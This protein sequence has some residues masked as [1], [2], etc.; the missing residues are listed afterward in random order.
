MFSHHTRVI[1][2][3][4]LFCLV[5][6]SSCTSPAS[7][8]TFSPTTTV[9]KAPVRLSPT[10]R[11]AGTPD[12]TPTRY[13]SHVVLRGVGRP[14]DLV[15]DEQG[16]LVFSDFYNGTISRLNANGSV[17][18]LVR[19]VA[20]PE[21]MVI[22]ADG[23]MII[24]EQ[25]TNRI[26]SLAPGTQM[27]KVLRALPGSP[28][29]VRC[30]DGVDGIALDAAT[31]TLIVPDS[32]I[33]NVYR[34]SLDGHTLTLLASGITRPVGAVVDARGTIYVADECGGALWKIASSG[35]KTR[36]GGFGMLDDVA[37][38]SR[39]NILVTDLAPTIHALVRV[40]LSTGRHETLASRGFIEPQG[41]LIDDHDNIFVADDYAN[42]IMEYKPT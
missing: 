32:P 4:T 33:G 28:R 20:G 42:I 36:M 16:H 39:G 34:M 15:F 5:V 23:T 29:P 12:T 21:G 14:D 6:L 25:R 35:K 9:T 11:T 7:S 22:L 24:A 40:R 19:G 30:K 1:C 37:I 31:N 8:A 3:I 2:T 17:T 26:L 41:L 27:P 10:P 38:D 13:T 18:V